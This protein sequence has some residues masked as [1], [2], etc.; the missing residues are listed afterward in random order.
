MP[1]NPTQHPVLDSIQQRWSPYRFDSKPVE[2]AKI[3]RCM[4]AARWAASSYND[5]P[6]S[7]MVARR[8]DTEAFEK[9]VG[10]LLEA[11]QAWAK[12]AGV[13]MISVIRTAFRSNGK[14]NRVA[15]HDLGQAAAHMA[16][17]ATEMGLQ[18]HQMAGVN[19]SAARLVYK[20]PEGHQPETAIALGYADASEPTDELGHEL[21]KRE[22][23]PR[24]RLSLGEQFFEGAWSDRAGFIPTT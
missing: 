24:T 13:L 6:W 17:Q 8:Q 21:K 14:P 10:C 9:M 12:N 4:E 7:W 2:D 11:N 19:L 3:L 18:V 1:I 5:Q 22:Q 23:G 15:L 20:I 16:L